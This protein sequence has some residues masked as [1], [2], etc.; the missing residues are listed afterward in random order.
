MISLASRVNKR[1]TWKLKRRMEVTVD[2]I[3][4]REVVKFL[5]M[6]SAYLIT[7]VI[8]SLLK[9]WLSIIF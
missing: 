2:S 6:L 3:M 7:I 4:D 5:R 1:F 8:N 9:V